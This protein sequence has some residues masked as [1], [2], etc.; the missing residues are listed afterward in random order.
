VRDVCRVILVHRAGHVPILVQGN[1]PDL[2]DTGGV[3]IGELH[4][5]L[6]GNGIEAINGHRG[7][8][9]RRIQTGLIGYVRPAAYDFRITDSERQP[10]SFRA[11]ILLSDIYGNQRIEDGKISRILYCGDKRCRIAVKDRH[12]ADPACGSRYERCKEGFR[13]IGELVQIV[14]QQGVWELWAD[15]LIVD[16]VSGSNV[17]SVKF[18]FTGEFFSTGTKK[19][20]ICII[21]RVRSAVFQRKI[22]DLPGTFR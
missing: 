9:R 4:L 20:A 21:H 1:C 18:G 11:G 7:L 14:H 12:D 16:P 10:L 13:A 22:L 6:L 8:D 2:E 17:V 15:C 19:V 5:P 3:A